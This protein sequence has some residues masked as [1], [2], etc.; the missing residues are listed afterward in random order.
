MS[1]ES[2]GGQM[3]V[4]RN[5]LVIR[6]GFSGSC[7]AIELRKAGIDVDLVEIDPGWR[8]YGA[9]ITLNGATLRALGQ[10][11]L[12][13]QIVAEGGCSDGEARF[14]PPTDTSS[15]SSRP[16][17]LA[18]TCP[19]AAKTSCRPVLAKILAEA[20]RGSGTQVR[21]GC[22]A[23]SVDQQER[24]VNVSFN[25]G[26]HASYDLV[27]AAD[28]ARSGMRDKLFPTAAK[29]VYTGQGVWRAVVPRP[30]EVQ[31]AAFFIGVRL[32]AGVV[33][34]SRTSMYLL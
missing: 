20:T 3:S 12:L 33:P 28:G 2:E 7:A 29:P 9:G 8:S 22:S 21:L 31:T 16:A 34:V 14:F 18:P 1:L 32:K 17:S 13:P 4:V 23:I 26:T 25:D 15:L 27:V 11:G 6:G 30:I 5:V 19:V 24:S 10:V